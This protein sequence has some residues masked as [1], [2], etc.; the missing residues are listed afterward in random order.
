MGD[1]TIKVIDNR[2][3]VNTEEDT[4]EETNKVEFYNNLTM[5]ARRALR[6]QP[7]EPIASV[8]KIYRATM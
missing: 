3:Y 2:L 5:D 1:N 7:Q 4:E 6:Y 8:V